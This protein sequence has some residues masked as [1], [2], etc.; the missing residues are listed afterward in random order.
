M[1]ITLL[2]LLLALLLATPAPS[3]PQLPHTEAPH[4]QQLFWGMI[5]PELALWFSRVPE[6][7][8]ESLRW[9]WSWRGFLSA[10][11]PQSLVKEVDHAPAV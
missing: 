6:D 11:F 2:S 1:C 3:V 8:D 7:A 5:D 10:L 4:P 9:D